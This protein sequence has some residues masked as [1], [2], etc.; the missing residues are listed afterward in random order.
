MGRNLNRYVARLQAAAHHDA[1]LARALL[2]VTNL[3]ASP[4]RIL[5]PGVAWGV[6]K[7]GSTRSP[8]RQARTGEGLLPA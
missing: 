7:G 6:L 3:V 4:E 5:S 8:P 1:A 2:E